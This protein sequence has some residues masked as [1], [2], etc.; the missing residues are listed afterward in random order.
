MKAP[1]PKYSELNEFY[2]D[3]DLNDDGRPDSQWESTNIVKIKPPFPM[4]WS[5]S[6]SPVKTISFHKKCASH[7]EK[8]LQGLG[9]AFTPEELI[10]YQ[11]NRCGGGYN[12]RPMVGKNILSAHAYG[13]AIDLATELNPLNKKW[14]PNARMMP[15][16]AVQIFADQ[17]L[18]WGG[19][20]KSRP[21]CMHFEAL[22]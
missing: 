20:Y 8:A 17:G 2:G 1:F 7:F 16:R 19:T 14:R 12:F 11:L 9:K 18:R 5:W 10:Y 4:Y 3:P 15:E 13:A 6:M 22:S 21:D